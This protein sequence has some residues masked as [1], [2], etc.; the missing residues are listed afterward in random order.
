MQPSKSWWV[1]V[2]GCKGKRNTLRRFLK[3]NQTFLK[4]VTLGFLGSLITDLH[5]DLK[6][7]KWRIQYGMGIRHF[8]FFNQIRLF[9]LDL[10]IQNSVFNVA[11]K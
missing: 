6:A 4:I 10:K 7:S 3:I 2:K 5:A 1:Y 8:E 9:R 11:V